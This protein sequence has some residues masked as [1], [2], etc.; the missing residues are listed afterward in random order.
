VQRRRVSVAALRAVL[1]AV[2]WRA[3]GFYTGYLFS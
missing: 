2:T 1:L 3:E